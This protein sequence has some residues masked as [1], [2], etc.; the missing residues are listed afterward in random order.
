LFHIIFPF[1]R[2]QKTMQMAG[3]VSA[4]VMKNYFLEEMSIIIDEEKGMTHEQ[5]T[6]KIDA[7]FGDNVEKFATKLRFPKVEVDALDWCYTPIIQSGGVYDLKPSAYSN[8]N[9]LHEGTILCSL[10]ARYKSYCSNIARTYMID[11]TKEQ[12]KNY[13]FLLD[14]QHHI[15]GYL[16]DGVKGKDIYGR[17][18][19]YIKNRRPDL[20]SHFLKN[21]GFGIGI[22][23]RESTLV[24]NAKNERVLRSGMVVNLVLGFQ[25]LE[26]KETEDLRNKTYALLVSDTVQITNGHPFIFTDDAPKDIA[27]VFF[28]F[29]DEEEKPEK[30]KEAI[31][32][33]AAVKS[34]AI[35]KS[36]TRSEGL[37]DE[38]PQEARRKQHQKQLAQQKQEEGLARFSTGDGD[39]NLAPKK[40][41]RK[42]ESYRKDTQ[43]PKETASLKILVDHKNQSIILPIYGLPVPF[44]IYTLKNVSKNDEGEYVYLRLNFITPGQTMVKK[45]ESP[46]EDPT[47]TFVKSMTYRSTDQ[48][49]MNEIYRQITDLKKL[50]LKKEAELKDIADIVQQDKLVEVKKGRPVILQDVF[51]RPSLEGKRVPGDLAI[52]MNGL[53]F[54]THL[55]A[56][57]DIMFNNIKHLF[58]QPCD[59]ELI[60]I[61][62]VHL[63]N[64]IMIGK[65]KTKDVQ[66]YREATDMAFDETGNR[67]RR[68]NYGDEDELAQ[69][70]AER[71][72]RA[73]L[74]KEFQNF[75]EKITDISDSKLDVDVPYRELGFNGVPFR[76]NVLLQPTAE[77]LVHLTEP[78]FLV[79]TLADVEIVHLE[80]VTFGL[81]N[82]DMVYVFK[83]FTRAPVHIN[84]ISINQLE[85]VKDWLEYVSL[86]NRIFLFNISKTD[87]VSNNNI[88]VAHQKFHSRKDLSI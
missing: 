28:Y 76:S 12:E 80:R 67:R 77:C 86:R 85:N 62:H 52:H 19:Q 72:H 54:S 47:A 22:E 87:N 88:F 71:A 10:G 16:R 35:L 53:R 82:F 26:T 46:F 5:L 4:A 15:L 25:N 57:V 51:I 3:K 55:K 42:F 29:D 40:T 31:K 74:N 45:D 34:S 66:F 48:Y 1:T 21:V 58:F 24:L 20:E 69:E 83:D 13:Q 8:D 37:E 11:P 75:T 78:P 56:G 2:D 79:I 43:L 63:K 36:K 30:P 18:Y 39:L 33:V 65:K 50:S 41:F 23:F 38:L 70:Q 84:S 59:N 44:H 14:L 61:L 68:A 17:A 32:P 9:N 27:S 64:P 6:A 7:V 49:R 60:V 73:R 81:K